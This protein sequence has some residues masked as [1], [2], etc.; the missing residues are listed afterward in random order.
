M[1]DT[2]VGVKVGYQR[3]NAHM[4]Q[5]HLHDAAADLS[6]AIDKGHEPRLSYF[7]R[8][9]VH[10]HSGLVDATYDDCSQAI[11]CGAEV[12]ELYRIR[13]HAA[14]RL[15]R[16]EQAEADCS[17]A[18]ELEPGNGFGLACWG[19]L[20]MARGEFGKAAD[21]YRAATAVDDNV[22][23]RFA[24]GLALLLDGRLEEARAIYAEGVR[25]PDPQELEIARVEL[26]YWTAQ[27]PEAGEAA[28]AIRPMLG[29]VVF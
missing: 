27:R 6:S 22:R 21:A 23:R 1:T 26:D 3:A 15:G 13:A 29:G 7:A 18:N 8:A 2:I 14:A 25:N 4:M 24:W 11:S 19:E 28:K 12:A 5:G 9:I 10:Y 20:H 17:K 16:L